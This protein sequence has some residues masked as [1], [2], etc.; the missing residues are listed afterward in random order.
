MNKVVSIILALAVLGTIG[1][2]GY[3]ISTPNTGEKF[4]EFYILGI[5]GRAEGYPET[6]TVEE[7]GKVLM[8]IV[9]QERTSVSYRVKILIAG[10]PNREIGPVELAHGEKWEE[11]VRF[12]VAESGEQQKV[13]FRLYKTILLGDSDETL[14]SFWIGQQYVDTRIV[15]NG[16]GETSYRIDLEI[17]E[18][19]ARETRTESIGPMIL[20]S[21]EDWSQE[22]GFSSGEIG[23]HKVKFSLYS[24]K[25]QL[26]T[27]HYVNKVS[28]FDGKIIYEETYTIDSTLYL[29]VDVNENN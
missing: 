13:E 22:Y 29:W 5:E 9:N 14:F 23:T 8:G 2:L 12:I 16:T 6:L 3:V 7:E 11:E 15:N 24:D 18:I 10:L 21:G 1:V 25:S 17:E 27:G 20:D 4:T 19:E 26:A 28:Q